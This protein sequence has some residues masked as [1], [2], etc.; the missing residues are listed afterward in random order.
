MDTITDQ[1]DLDM[2]EKQTN[3]L[4]NAYMAIRHGV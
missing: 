4:S 1:E 2:I 3:D